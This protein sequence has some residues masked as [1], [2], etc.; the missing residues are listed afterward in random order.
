M[1]MF[2]KIYGSVVFGIDVLMIIIE[3]NIVNGVNF[4]LVGLFDNVVKE[5]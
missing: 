5:S 3:V 4:M 1:N 2:V